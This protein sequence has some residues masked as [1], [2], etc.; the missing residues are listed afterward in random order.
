MFI[1]ETF[2][3]VM[4][5]ACSLFYS[6]WIDNITFHKISRNHDDKCI[7][8]NSITKFVNYV[9]LLLAILLL[10][11]HFLIPLSCGI[12]TIND[13]GNINFCSS[14]QFFR[15]KMMTRSVRVISSTITLT[16]PSTH[17]SDMI[18]LVEWYNQIK[19]PHSSDIGVEMINVAN[20]YE[21]KLWFYIQKIKHSAISTDSMHQIS[22]YIYADI[23]LEINGP[24][25][26]RYVDPTVNI[27]ESELKGYSILN[28]LTI[29]H[30]L[31][32]PAPFFDWVLPRITS[33]RGHLWSNYFQVLTKMAINDQLIINSTFKVHSSEQ[34]HFLAETKPLWTTTMLPSV[35]SIIIIRGS[36][37]V[38]IN[39]SQVQLISEGG[40]VTAGTSITWRPSNSTD[41]NTVLLMLLT[42]ND[43]KRVS[44]FHNSHSTYRTEITICNAKQL[45]DLNH[46]SLPNKEL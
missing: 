1:I 33:Y 43:D 9:C 3:W 7:A 41:D 29:D 44:I 31:G 15:W 22:P 23:W 46:T 45:P 14:C 28:T 19:L 32:K 5:S 21:D 25:A 42:N 30:I 13:D 36:I 34:I 8:H 20:Y 40:C 18:H 35:V 16:N 24:P 39:P 12:N 11:I 10:L 27:A 26:Q 6:H 4:I 38:R 37:E 17:H 2:P